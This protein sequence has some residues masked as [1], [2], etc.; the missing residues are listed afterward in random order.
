MDLFWSIYCNVT[1]SDIVTFP[2]PVIGHV[3]C[4]F[5]IFMLISTCK[6]IKHASNWTS[7]GIDLDWCSC[8]S[9]VAS[10]S[11]GWG[12]SLWHLTGALWLQDCLY[13]TGLKFTNQIH[14][15]NDLH[16]YPTVQCKILSDQHYGCRFD[17][18][19]KFSCVSF[20]LFDASLII[21][22]VTIIP[23]ET[24]SW[25]MKHFSEVMYDHWRKLSFDG[26]NF[27][28]FFECQ[29]STLLIFYVLFILRNLCTEW[30]IIHQYAG[31][32]GPIF[33]RWVSAIYIHSHMI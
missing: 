13:E 26:C 9:I 7:C 23:N 2:L 27:L 12:Q 20:F 3:K 6:L 8:I 19:N 21:Q 29:G 15:H 30:I 32:V 33:L 31:G 18:L 5:I 14:T 11:W 22:Y 4:M 16:K 10:C 1:L 24:I 25:K 28:L 17:S